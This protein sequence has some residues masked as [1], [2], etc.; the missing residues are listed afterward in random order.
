MVIVLST[1]GTSHDLQ[2]N[3]NLNKYTVLKHI[4][5]ADP[6]GGT[7][8]T[9]ELLFFYAQNDNFSLFFFARD[10]N[11]S[12]ILIEIRPKHA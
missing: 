3:I 11:L 5:L 7:A 9:Y 12:I 1:K 8:R 4:P 6:G 2:L 10:L